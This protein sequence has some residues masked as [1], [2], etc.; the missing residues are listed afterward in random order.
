MKLAFEKEKEQLKRE[1]L[2]MEIVKIDYESMKKQ[3]ELSNS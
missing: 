2:N 3:L 1:I